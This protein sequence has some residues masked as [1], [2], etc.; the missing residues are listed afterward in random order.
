MNAVNLGK[1]TL[2]R[3]LSQEQLERVF[4]A[5]QE[6]SFSS[7]MTV[8]EEASTDD[9]CLYVI[10]EGSVKVHKKGFYGGK[11]TI[12]TLHTGDH[13]GEVSL[14]DE[15]PRSAAVTAIKPCRL[16]SLPKADLRAIMGADP[17]LAAQIYE[18]LI[19]ELCSRLRDTNDHLIYLKAE[20]GDQ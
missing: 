19:A 16:L 3:Q 20:G 11:E 10:M 12:T 13:F 8:I 18:T 7:G 9:P 17:L 5:C 4:A 1:V 6:R 2:F 15:A 14:F